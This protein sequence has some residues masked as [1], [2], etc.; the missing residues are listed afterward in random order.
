[1]KEGTRVTG[2][3]KRREKKLRK[4]EEEGNGKNRQ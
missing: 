1:V 2:K 3:S 4:R